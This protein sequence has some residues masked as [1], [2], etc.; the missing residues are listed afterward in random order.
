MRRL[1]QF[2]QQPGADQ[3]KTLAYG[4]A[5]YPHICWY[6][7]AGRDFRHIQ[8]L[9]AERLRGDSDGPPLIYVHSDM[10]MELPNR[11]RADEAPF[12]VGN[13]VA[14]GIEI[15]ECF[16]ITPK[17]PY[18][19]PSRE[20]WLLGETSFSGKVFALGLTIHRE[21]CQR[22]VSISVPVIY[23]GFENLNLL[24]DFFVANQLRVHTL[25]HINDGGGTLGGSDLPMNFIYQA[26]DHLRIRRVISDKSMGT[27]PFNMQ[28]DCHALMHQCHGSRNYAVRQALGSTLGRI[29]ADGVD[30]RGQ[31]TEV[32]AEG[33]G[34]SPCKSRR[35]IY[36]ASRVGC[37]KRARR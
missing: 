35:P 15:S 9:E 29:D 19:R 27:R 2:F 1:Y 28:K 36:D 18:Y 11:D 4:V 14:E 3:V 8:Y 21:H 31:W 32:V 6:P 23:F 17:Q 16:E 33:Y 34:R 12:A 22:A 20:I 37:R 30:F 13:V 7:S 25:V 26:A 24:V 5:S 10:G